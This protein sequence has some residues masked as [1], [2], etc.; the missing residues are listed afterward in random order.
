MTNRFT[1]KIQLKFSSSSVI[2]KLASIFKIC[3]YR[4]AVIL[5]DTNSPV[6][7]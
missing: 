6:L 5:L 4:V 7:A 1:A 3:P 2:N